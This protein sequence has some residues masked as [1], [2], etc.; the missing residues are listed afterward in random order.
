MFIFPKKTL[1]C[2]CV[3]VFSCEINYY[4]LIIMNFGCWRE[5]IERSNRNSLNL[6]AGFILCEILDLF[7]FEKL[8][9]CV[10]ECMISVKNH[11]CKRGMKK[12]FNG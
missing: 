5:K 3:R 8:C 11:R 1:L 9:V 7:S 4:K 12:W 2:V 6:L 10:C